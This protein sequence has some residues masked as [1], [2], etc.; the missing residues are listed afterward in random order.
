MHCGVYRTRDRGVRLPR[1]ARPISGNLT[2]APTPHPNGTR[3]L[4]SLVLEPTSTTALLPPLHAARVG[5]ITASGIVIQGVELIAR[6]SHSKANVERFAQTWW[7]L[8]HTS[9]LAALLDFE[10]DEG[11]WANPGPT[12]F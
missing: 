12:G 10:G 2:L 9:N 11:L 6:S 7:C 5:P 4:A 8:V 3:L 1:P